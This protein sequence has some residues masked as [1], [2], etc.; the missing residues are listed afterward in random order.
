MVY[1]SSTYMIHTNMYNLHIYL[2]LQNGQGRH[3]VRDPVP[4]PHLRPPG[5]LP[6]HSLPQQH[7]RQPRIPY[8]HILGQG[9]RARS[10]KDGVRPVHV[11]KC[12]M[13]LLSQIISK[14][15]TCMI[16]QVYIIKPHPLVKH[17]AICF[18]KLLSQ[19]NSKSSTCMIT[20]V[21]IIKLHPP[22]T[23]VAICILKLLSQVISKNSTCMI[24]TSV[25]HKTPPT[26]EACGISITS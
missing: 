10:V 4:R 8:L 7:P 21:Y 20:Q 16:A 22:V 1:T 12:I 19:I 18:M 23:H 5:H 2:H 17:V 13:K 14:S 24:C 25:H 11:A 15:S 9:P 26:C 3:H 6:R